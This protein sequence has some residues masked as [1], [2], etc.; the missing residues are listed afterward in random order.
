VSSGFVTIIE[1][2]TGALSVIDS[3][4]GR[5]MEAVLQN[6]VDVEGIPARV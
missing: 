5:P 3:E 2:A 6:Y 4:T 1:D